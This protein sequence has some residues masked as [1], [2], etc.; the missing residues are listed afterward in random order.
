MNSNNS[1]VVPTSFAIEN[2]SIKVTFKNGTVVYMIAEITDNYMTF[3]I[4][5]AL[6]TST[7]RITFANLITN[8]ENAVDKDDF[9]LNGIAMTYWTNPN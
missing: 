4:E 5:T 6:P 1:K 9:M 7:S 8:L 2:N 3:E